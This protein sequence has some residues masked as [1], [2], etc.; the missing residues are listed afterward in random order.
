MLRLCTTFH[1][2]EKAIPGRHGPPGIL[3]PWLA[4][5]LGLAALVMIPETE[6][7]NSAVAADVRPLVVAGRTS[8]ASAFTDLA[9]PGFTPAV[10]SSTSSGVDGLVSLASATA[11]SPLPKPA[12]LDRMFAVS[13]S[14]TRAFPEGFAHPL[15]TT[16]A[17]EGRSVR[18]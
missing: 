1:Q 3:A 7:S 16:I 11:T 8:L 14:P 6:V 12:M 4:T 17:Q 18:S 15:L 9:T 2:A 10:A 13:G 5:G